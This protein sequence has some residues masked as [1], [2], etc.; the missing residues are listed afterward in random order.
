MGQRQ[1]QRPTQRMIGGIEHGVDS[2]RDKALHI[3]TATAIDPTVL[4]GRLKRRKG[5]G[6]PRC[7][8]HVGMA[9]EQ[10]PRHLPRT[11]TGEQVG[12]FAAGVLDDQRL[13]ALGQ[14]QIA[15]VLNQGHV[16]FRRN[17]F[18]GHQAFKNVQY[19]G[20]HEALLRCS[21]EEAKRLMENGKI[22]VLVLP[23]LISSAI[24]SPT[25]GPSW[26]P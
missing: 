16:R 20:L 14:Q 2:Q 3:A 7:R 9:G 26:K 19:T 15:H 11:G 12:L 1:L 21:T 18:K 25:P 17:G 24:T 23:V 13:D 6:L 8:H 22:E 5:P 10:N 4:H